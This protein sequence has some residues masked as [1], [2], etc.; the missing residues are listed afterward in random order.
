VSGQWQRRQQQ[1]QQQQPE[2]QQQ[3]QQRLQQC[4][5]VVEDSCL[6]MSAVVL[7]MYTCLHDLKLLASV[8]LLV[9]VVSEVC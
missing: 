4:D 2:Q 6:Q 3:Q 9:A 1:Q 8:T 5:M 7:L